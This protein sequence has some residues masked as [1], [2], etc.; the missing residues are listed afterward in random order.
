MLR[1]EY[2]AF[3][4]AII[5]GDSADA[6]RDKF[7][8]QLQQLIAQLQHEDIQLAWLTLG[9]P[10]ATLIGTA[11]A[12]GFVFHNCLETEVTLIIRLRS[13]AFA[14]FAPTHTL[15]AGAFILRG[16]RELLV[17]KE[18]LNPQWGYKL[19]GGHIELGEKIATAIGRE[20]FEET[21]VRTRFNAILGVASKHPYRFGK[22]N[23]Y[24]LCGLSCD[25]DRIQIQDTHEIE[26][27]KWIATE[28]YLSDERNSIFNRR[29][30]NA[31]LNGG[32]L[33]NIDLDNDASA[34]N[35]HEVFFTLPKI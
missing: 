34:A 20:V 21:G 22:S 12:C 11:T 15:G 14:P 1:F 16:N 30:V 32:G 3:N 35:K 28:A 24:F 31:A 18:R 9:L 26:D 4:G 5:D 7:A 19:P 27:A 6:C 17:I 10:Q 8:R 29:M 33:I 25:D 13:E 23:L 2:D